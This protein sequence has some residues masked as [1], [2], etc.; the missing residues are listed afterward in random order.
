MVIVL[1]RTK[2]RA[3]ADVAAYEALGAR[4]FEIVSAMPGFLGAQD[5][6]SPDGDKVSVIRFASQEA[7]RAWREE[8]S[9]V[10]AQARGKAE[11]YASYEIEVCEVVRA[12]GGPR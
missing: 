11:F 7:L 12:Y 2:L 10:L 4:M 1:V 9:H 3:D 8:P 6:A 5:Y